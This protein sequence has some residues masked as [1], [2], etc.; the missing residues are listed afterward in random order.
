M[1]T[2][3]DLINS[4]FGWFHF[5][6]NTGRL[7]SVVEEGLTRAGVVVLREDFVGVLTAVGARG[8]GL[9]VPSPLGAVV[10]T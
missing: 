4:A 9:H 5:L 3:T 2:V 10:T 8:V 7:G 6:L 1:I